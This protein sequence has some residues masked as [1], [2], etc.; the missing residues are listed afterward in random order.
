MAIELPPDVLQG[1]IENVQY[2]DAAPFAPAPVAPTDVKRA[3]EL[4]TGAKF[5]VIYA[6]GVSWLSTL[7]G[8]TIRTAL[9]QGFVPYVA[10]DLLKAAVAAKILPV[11][12]RVLG[13]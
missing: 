12:W 9:A 1:A 11:A 7:P 6:G 4:L 13:K 2:F 10:L 5:P 3:A 8:Q